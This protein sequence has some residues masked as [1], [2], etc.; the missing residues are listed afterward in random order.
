MAEL[1]RGW[2]PHSDA[3]GDGNAFHYT[4]TQ[5]YTVCFYDTYAYCDTYTEL[6]APPHPHADRGNPHVDVNRFIVPDVEQHSEWDA[7]IYPDAHRHRDV[8]AHD[9]RDARK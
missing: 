6:N 5:Y 3:L 4:N 9:D 1:A 8:D 7:H 2:P